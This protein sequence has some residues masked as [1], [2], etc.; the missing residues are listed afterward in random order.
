MRLIAQEEERKKT[1][2]SASH[3]STWDI[4]D[5]YSNELPTF[6]T[7]LFGLLIYGLT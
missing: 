1:N 3:K 4:F 6:I 2:T 5:A 7:F